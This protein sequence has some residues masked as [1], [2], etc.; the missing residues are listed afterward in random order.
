MNIR[1]VRPVKQTPFACLTLL[2]AQADDRLVQ[3]YNQYMKEEQRL[4]D[5]KVCCAM[6]CLL[7]TVDLGLGLLSYT[8]S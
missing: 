4:I 7:L 1:R 2:T 8:Y 6:L 3:E 5:S